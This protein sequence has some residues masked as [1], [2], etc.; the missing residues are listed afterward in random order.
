MPPPSLVFVEDDEAIINHKDIDLM[1]KMSLRALNSWAMLVQAPPSADS[2]ELA[3]S[4]ASAI[5]PHIANSS[6]SIMVD[7]NFVSMTIA[8]LKAYVKDNNIKC[9]RRK[10]EDY[11]VAITRAQQ[12]TNDDSADLFRSLQ[13]S[14]RMGGDHHHAFYK[15]VFNGID[16][17][18]KRWY[19]LRYQHTIT[20]WNTKLILSILQSCMI[21]AWVLYKFNG[22]NV[23][24]TEFRET[25]IRSIFDKTYPREEKEKK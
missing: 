10:K 2:A 14:A 12:I 21:N 13:S 17:H 8:A 7:E 24:L 3:R 16:M 1:S 22:P 20:K 4:I 11:L 19:E 15:K 23:S 25:I 9:K 5:N 6:Q 18:D